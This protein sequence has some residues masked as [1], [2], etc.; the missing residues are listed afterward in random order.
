MS[1]VMQLLDPVTLLACA[2]ISTAWHKIVSEDDKRFAL[3]LEKID[4]MPTSV[5]YLP[6][7]EN[8]KTNYKMKYLIA[9]QTEVMSRRLYFQLRKEIESFEKAP[10]DGISFKPTG[11]YL[12]W[13]ARIEGP[14]ASPYRSGVFFLNIKIPLTYPLRYPH[15]HFTTKIFH[16]NITENGTVSLAAILNIW[17]V[18]SSTHLTL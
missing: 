10:I 16:P 18:V 8:P 7:Y 2:R 3:K 14:E 6:I 15:V 9:T 13:S 17:Y 1:L 12:L 11:N 5:F 4:N